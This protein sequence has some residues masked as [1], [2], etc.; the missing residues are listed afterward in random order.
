MTLAGVAAIIIGYL[1]GIIWVLGSLA[2]VLFMLGVVRYIYKP[3]D[4][5]SRKHVLWSLV[6]LFVLF[7]LWGILRLACN[8]LPG[9]FCGSGNNAPLNIVPPGAGWE[10]RGVPGTR[11]SGGTGG[12]Y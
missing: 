8:S 1:N 7:S 6:A 9:N 11:A 10:Y 5:G 12:L 3:T 2:L 4:K